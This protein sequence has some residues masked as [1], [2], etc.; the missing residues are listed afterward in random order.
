M[1]NGPFAP[2]KIPAKPEINPQNQS[3]RIT[4]S[5]KL[6]IGAQVKNRIVPAII[7]ISISSEILPNKRIP[8]K[9]PKRVEI[10][11]F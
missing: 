10:K 2:I 4:E 8:P 3:F 1:T 11:M 9:A 7:H 5:I 6:S